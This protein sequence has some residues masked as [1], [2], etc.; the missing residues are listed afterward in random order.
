MSQQS[1]REIYFSFFMFTADLLPKGQP[2][3]TEVLLRH[4]HKLKDMGY[5]GFDLHI[6]DRPAS[7]FDYE[8]EV[9]DYCRLKQA[10]DKEGFADMKFATNVGT[11][12]E[13][14]PTSPSP[15]TRELALRY[16]KS[17]VDITRALGGEWAIMSGPFLY[18]YGAFP[19]K[20]GT[21][22][23]KPVR[24]D[25][26][27]WSDALQDWI[28]PR[29]RNAKCAFKEL[30]DYAA[31]KKVKLA[32]EPVKNWESPPPN[33]VSE[34]LDFVERLQSAPCGMTI[35]TAQVLMESQGPEIYRNNVERAG[36]LL[37]YVHISA[38]DRGAIHDSWIPWNLMLGPLEEPRTGAGDERRFQGP[39]LIE[40]F[41]AIPPF[42][43]LMRMSRR[44]FWWRDEDNDRPKDLNAYYI[45][46]QALKE[47]RRQ[48]DHIRSASDCGDVPGVSQTSQRRETALPPE[49]VVGNVNVGMRSSPTD[50]VDYGSEDNPELFPFI[51]RTDRYGGLYNA[52]RVHTFVASYTENNI[53]N[54]T[55][56]IESANA[57]VVVDGQ[58]RAPYA[59][60]F[61]A[62]VDRLKKKIERVYLSHR[63][64]DHWYGMPVAFPDQIIYALPGTIQWVKDNGKQSLQNHV[65]TLKEQIGEQEANKLVPS[66]RQFTDWYESLST[67]MKRVEPHNETIDGVQYEFEEVK[68]AEVETQLVIKLPEFGV[69][70]VQDLLYSGT[71]L[72]LS[73]SMD[74]WRK[75]LRDL[76][77]SDYKTFLPGH[78]RIVN[79]EELENNIEYLIAAQRAFDNGKSE[80]DLEKYLV[81]RYP[82]RL[83]QGI[84]P[85]CLPRL[86][87]RAGE[88]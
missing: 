1:P 40:I 87:G 38:P 47:L 32:L 25:A 55:H 22:P 7:V 84:F 58:F 27:L 85:I 39:Y 45:A 74:N 12:S 76:N 24:S 46:E 57:L 9:G 80:D 16:L 60:Q 14:D 53:A 34:V 54:A 86:Y 65:N 61:R 11:T 83:C 67:N 35:D 29:M 44:W 5:N 79:K 30:A 72:Y 66:A 36:N 8:K 21:F 28:Q 33:M 2:D 77:E 59:R 70:I 82:A 10:F 6:A 71:H 49:T 51:V 75:I 15:E 68:D 31:Y 48:I 63:H 17:R 3:Y 73:R 4:M 41:N 43:A 52:V 81:A 23:D 88:V 13:Y 69:A 18:P 50:C 78:G 56:V 37:N 42:D 19:D 62:Y 20:H 64:P 26:L